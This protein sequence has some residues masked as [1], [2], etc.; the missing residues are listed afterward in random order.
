[1]T[2][3]LLPEN[4]RY[5]GTTYQIY[6]AKCDTWKDA[7]KENFYAYANR[8]SSPCITCLLKASKARKMSGEICHHDGCIKELYR[9]NTSGYCGAHAN[10]H[11][12]NVLG[13]PRCTNC[14]GPMKYRTGTGLCRSCYVSTG[15]CKMTNANNAQRVKEEVIPPH[16]ELKPNEFYSRLGELP[17]PLGI[18]I[19]HEPWR[20]N[21]Q[22][23]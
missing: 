22:P 3:Q 19:C 4:R 10:M 14:G 18:A 9:D 13:R 11:R 23:R 6:C 1:M 5:L 20:K 21:E 16:D 17:A 7:T 2:V 15:A 12:G 8:L